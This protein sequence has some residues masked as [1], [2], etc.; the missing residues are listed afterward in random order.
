MAIIIIIIMMSSATGM[1]IFVVAVPV[2][3]T[4]L[5]IL[6]LF[7][8]RFIKSRFLEQLSSSHGIIHHRLVCGLFLFLDRKQRVFADLGR[9]VSSS[10]GILSLQKR[11]LLGGLLQ[12]LI[13]RAL[14]EIV[15]P[16]LAQE[17]PFH[18]LRSALLAG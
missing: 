5:P 18:F 7:C 12:F 17:I 2:T 3:V 9:R 13:L 11:I 10:V 8:R 1:P 6:I 15:N 14:E 4:M 16:S